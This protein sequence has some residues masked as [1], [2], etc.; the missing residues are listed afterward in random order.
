M[1]ARKKRRKAVHTARFDECVK[2]VRRRGAAVDP[3]AVC[4]ASL[5][6][7]RSILKRSRR[8]NPKRRRRRARQVNPASFVITG[9]RPRGKKLLY[10]GSK[11]EARGNPVH[12]PTRALAASFAGHL[13]RSFPQ[14]SKV[15]LRVERG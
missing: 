3:Y 8:A 7:K 4:E 1:A 9:K 15:S 6:E 12:F 14:L 10:T 5:G 2:D 11:L 13:K